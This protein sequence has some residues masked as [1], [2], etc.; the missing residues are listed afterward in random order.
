M[1]KLILKWFFFQKIPKIL[2]FYRISTEFLA[3]NRD[4]LTAKTDLLI[5]NR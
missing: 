3:Q 4:L 2:N 1:Q 5:R